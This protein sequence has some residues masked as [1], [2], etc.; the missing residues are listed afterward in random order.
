MIVKT[1]FCL[2]LISI[3]DEKTIDSDFL[4]NS[5]MLTEDTGQIP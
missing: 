2:L 5:E 3:D 4:H 1:F